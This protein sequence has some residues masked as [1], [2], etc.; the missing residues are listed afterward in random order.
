MEDGSR[1][2]YTDGEGFDCP[3]ERECWVEVAEEEAEW[4]LVNL[5]SQEKEHGG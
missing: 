5:G 3:P 1:V 2:V 4:T